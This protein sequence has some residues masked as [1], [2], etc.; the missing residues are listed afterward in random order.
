M[1]RVTLDR[2][3]TNP[4]EYLCSVPSTILSMPPAAHITRIHMHSQL[5]RCVD[6][7]L[8]FS[9]NR[10]EAN[11]QRT[12]HDQSTRED[13]VTASLDITAITIGSWI[14]KMC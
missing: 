4:D 9:T 5:V 7:S 11:K 14:G 12:N 8:V 10:N 6:D 2:Q 3:P 13:G 1:A